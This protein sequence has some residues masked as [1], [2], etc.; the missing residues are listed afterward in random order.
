M[1][2]QRLEIQFQINHAVAINIAILIFSLMIKHLKEMLVTFSHWNTHNLFRRM[3]L[4]IR[5]SVTGTRIKRGSS[6]GW[7]RVQPLVCKWFFVCQFL[8]LLI[9]NKNWPNWNIRHSV[10][11]SFILH[12][13]LLWINLLKFGITAPEFS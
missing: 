12:W 8:N 11:T 3:T 10:L 1:S 4:F 9:I 13:T 7:T 5:Y 2:T 6:S